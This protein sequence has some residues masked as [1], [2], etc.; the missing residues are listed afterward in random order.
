MA[1]AQQL[2]TSAFQG[3][4]DALRRGRGKGG[5][6]RSFLSFRPLTVL[7]GRVLLGGTSDSTWR[8]KPDSDAPLSSNRFRDPVVYAGFI[9]HSPS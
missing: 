8:P 6:W 5:L 4:F 7:E 1:Y 9:L 2:P 3:E